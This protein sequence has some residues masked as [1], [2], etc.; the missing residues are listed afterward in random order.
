MMTRISRS[1]GIGLVVL[2]AALL[3][4]LS[5]ATSQEEQ[6]IVV[7]TAV[8]LGC[9]Q[10][11]EE[12]LEFEGPEVVL[13]Y[14]V[15]VPP[16]AELL[17]Y[18]KDAGRPGD[19]WEAC[20]TVSEQPPA[21]LLAI[22]EMGGC[23]RGDGSFNYSPPAA[24]VIPEGKAYVSVRYLKGIEIWPAHMW[25]KFECQCPTPPPEVGK[26][27]AVDRVV[28]EVL[29]G[30][31]E[32]KA[33]YVL[34]RPLNPGETVYNW[35]GEPIYTAPQPVWYVFVDDH[36]S[37]NFEHPTRH[38]FVDVAT[39][40]ILQVIPATTPPREL[41]V[42]MEL[43]RMGASPSHS[44]P[45]AP[46]PAGA[47]QAA[48]SIA[49]A[50]ATAS[51]LS[52]DVWTDKP[53][54]TIGETVTIHFSTNR[55]CTAK[56]T[57]IKP[58]GTQTVWGPNN[59]PAGTH[60]IT[61]TAGQ[62][63]GQRHVILEAWRG[64]E[65]KVAETFFN[66]VEP[67]E[68]EPGA[69]QPQPPQPP[70]PPSAPP[71]APEE[72]QPPPGEGPGNL[73][74]VP[75]PPPVPGGLY[76][77]Y[78][79]SYTTVGV[80]TLGGYLPVYLHVPS[81]G[82]IWLFEYYW[83]TG[84]WRVYMFLTSA[85]WKRFWFYGDVGGWHSIIAFAG[86]TWTNWV[87][88]YVSGAP[89][90]PPTPSCSVSPTSLNFGT[91]PVGSSASLSFTITNT[92]G[93]TLSGTVTEACPDFSVFPN[94]YSL[95]PGASQAFTVTF[96]PTSPGYKSCT[97][98]TTS[99]C[100]NVFAEGTGAGAPPPPP[101]GNK[102]AVLISGGVDAASNYPRYLND[103]TEI[104]WTLRNVYGYPDANIFVLYADGPGGTQGGPSWVDYPATKANVL[105]VFSHLQAIMTP[106]DQLFVYVTNHGG[107]ITSG[108][109]QAK[110]WLWNYDWIADWEFANA[111]N[112]LRGWKYLVFEQ[113]YSGG[114]IDNLAGPDKVIATA[115]DWDEPSWACDGVGDYGDCGSWN[116]DEFVLHWTAAV[117]G[118]SPG[119][120]P[121]NADVDGSGMVELDEAFNYAR[122]H[123]SRAETPQYSDPG[124]IG[125]SSTL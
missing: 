105:A 44:Q 124:L 125:G 32:D 36:F 53:E 100:S 20:I 104:Y 5:V 70:P 7:P 73:F 12:Y 88:I 8:E 29:Y 35:A 91:V 75:S 17:V 74:L 1:I 103:L 109:N 85:G 23:T 69:G 38:A 71:G 9:G 113:C 80:T 57:I 114:M 24:V 62:P 51:E 84:Q 58:D 81:T 33:V 25:V 52:I 120:T 46:T 16:G 45:N 4:S 93:G 37:A 95:G 77:Y 2:L 6:I 115:A 121:V 72:E 47:S 27:Q 68:G 15:Y 82:L 97:I 86:G 122:T 60:S 98:Y 18:V 11:T 123:D 22:T 66:V 43:A 110:I 21:N 78:M 13:T 28:Q 65:H 101:P 107:Q 64:A 67:G 42:E 87:H 92:G 94:S 63:P 111:V 118:R 79:G 19:I 61:G 99:P 31:L 50:G 34:P 59:I 102:Y 10:V 96:T 90:P 117:K 112:P 55:A 119:G 106:S 89:P 108:T 49:G 76:V 48:E 30:V 54:Y 41:F 14:T 26:E 83:D 3:L 116:Y 56:L 39:G 40:V